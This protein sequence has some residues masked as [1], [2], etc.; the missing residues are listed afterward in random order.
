M[1]QENMVIGSLIG[2]LRK[3]QELTQTQLSSG[4]LARNTIANIE[5]GR[6]KITVQQLLVILD[7][8]N[9]TFA[10][11]AELL[12]ADLTENKRKS[13]IS[14]QLSKVYYSKQQDFAHLINEAE[15]FYLQSNDI[16]FLLFKKQAQL[17]ADREGKIRLEKGEREEIKKFFKRYL[18]K[19]DVWRT[20][21]WVLF[22]NCMFIFDSEFIY[23]NLRKG[24]QSLDPS[25]HGKQNEYFKSYFQ[26]LITNGIFLFLDRGHLKDSKNLLQLIK[27]QELSYHEF[28]LKIMIRFFEGVISHIESKQVNEKIIDTFRIFKIANERQQVERLKRFLN[29]LQIREYDQY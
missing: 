9:I 3:Q 14:S 18:G 2:L 26:I 16:F 23:L 7:R 24:V 13:Y 20:V 1:E 11:F 8:L 5:Y 4:I 15:L 19:F 25:K 22:I 12:P 28:Y 21:Q 29:A 6:S 17:L 27:K 10:E